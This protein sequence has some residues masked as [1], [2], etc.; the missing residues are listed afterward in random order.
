MPRFILLL[1][2][3]SGLSLSACAAREFAATPISLADHVAPGDIYAG[4][5]LLGALRLSSSE[6]NGLRL[7]GLS[8]L[9]WD[10]GA[11]LLYAISDQGALF[12]LRPVFDDQG[13]LAGARSIAAY[14]LQDASGKPLRTPFDDS[15]G[16]AIRNGDHQ[17]QGDTELL[18][19]FEVKPRVV[20]YSTKGEWRGEESLPAVLRDIRNYRDPNQ[21]LEAVTLD[22]RWGVLVGTE[23]PLRNDP[24]GQIRIFT[25]SGRFWIYPLGSAPSSAL[26]AM[27]ALPDGSLLTLERAFVAPLRPLVISLRRTELPVLGTAGVPL[28]VTDIAVFDSSQGW[29]LD[30]FEG[31]TRYRDQRFFMVSDDNCNSWQTTLLVYFELLPVAPVSGFR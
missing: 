9:A 21:A 27:E 29:L 24:S 8:G 28:K 18:I 13:Y 11:G 6:I 19:S 7:C 31:L 22:P 12:H 30:N 25:S 5:R 10:E 14:P 17:I 4:I 15:E 26:V 3:L 20:R 16:L 1:V 2:L 23:T